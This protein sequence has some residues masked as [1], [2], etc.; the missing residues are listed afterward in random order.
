MSSANNK[1]AI[2]LHVYLA[3]AGVASRRKSEELIAAGRVRVNGK[4]VREQGV[5]V[6]EQDHVTYNGKTVRPEKH[7]VYVVLHKPP[8]VLCTNDDPQGRPLA[9]DLV[10]D[11]YPLRLHSVG[12]LDYLSSG[13]ILFTNDGSF[14]RL[15]SHPSAEIEKEY[16]VHGA[17]HIPDELLD[18]FK[19]GIEV[20]GVWY[21]IRSYRRKNTHSAYLVLIEGKNREIRRVLHHAGI[22]PKRVHRVRIGPVKIN[23]LASGRFR[24]LTVRELQWFQRQGR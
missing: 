2:R 14:T 22:K 3:R 4:T 9:V 18:R 6:G 11:A 13:L 12:R 15:V 1:N 24:E 10:K 19:S 7:H 17:N 16:L 23:G 8:H 21:S 20:E 5:L